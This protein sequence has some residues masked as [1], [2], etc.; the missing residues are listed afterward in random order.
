MKTLR[1]SSCGSLSPL[2]ADLPLG[3]RFPLFCRKERVTHEHEVV[4][5]EEGGGP[6][7]S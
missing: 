3:T 4:V 7:R 5:A 2:V 1:C 6:S